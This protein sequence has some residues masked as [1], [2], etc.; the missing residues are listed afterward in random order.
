MWTADISSRMA[1]RGVYK[2]DQAQ[3]LR[4]SLRCQRWGGEWKRGAEAEGLDGSCRLKKQ[5][6]DLT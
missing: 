3:G 4:G 5:D 1:V 6:T 2:R